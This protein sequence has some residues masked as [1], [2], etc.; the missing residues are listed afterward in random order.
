MNITCVLYLRTHIMVSLRYIKCGSNYQRQ[1]LRVQFFKEIAENWTLLS[2]K[3]WLGHLFLPGWFIFMVCLNYSSQITLIKTKNLISQKEMNKKSWERDQ[4]FPQLSSFW[5]FRRCKKAYRVHK[6]SAKIG[7]HI[8]NAVKAEE[9]S[10]LSS[11]ISSPKQRHS[12]KRILKDG[13]SSMET[14]DLHP[15]PTTFIGSSDGDYPAVKSFGDAKTICLEETQKL[16]VIAGPIAFNILCNYGINSF[17]N[18]F[19]GHIGDL[20]LSA[21]AISLSV[22]QNFSFGFL[23]I[24]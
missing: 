19:V 4:N 14:V 17:T 13:V 5:S 6:K 11:P 2:C 20:E 23:V 9:S 7:T 24:Y 3:L 1:L 12:P 18:I 10:R 16:W 15:A 8:E 21:V 22:I